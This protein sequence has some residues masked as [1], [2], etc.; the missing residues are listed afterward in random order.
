MSLTIALASMMDIGV[1]I[2]NIASVCFAE[3]DISQKNLKIN[4]SKLITIIGLRMEK[5]GFTIQ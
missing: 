5:F 2:N 1:N 4:T 3:T